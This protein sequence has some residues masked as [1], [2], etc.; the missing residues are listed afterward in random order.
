MKGEGNVKI[1]FSSTVEQDEEIDQ[2]IKNLRESVLPSYVSGEEWNQYEKMGLLQFAQHGNLYNGTLREAYQLMTALQTVTDLIHIVS[3]GNFKVEENYFEIFQK[4]SNKLNYFGLF[5][6][7]DL[8]F[9]LQDKK[10][11]ISYYPIIQ[12]LLA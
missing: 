9:F 3:T 11:K 4:N 12:E 10:R 8:H 6:P 7:F 1:V 2:L 5:F